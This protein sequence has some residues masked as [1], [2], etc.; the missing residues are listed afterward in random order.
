M[1]KIFEEE[2]A[3]DKKYCKV[4]DHFHCTGKSRGAAHTICNLR[5]SKPKNIPVISQN[6]SNYDYHFII[7][8]LAKE[9]GKINNLRKQE[10]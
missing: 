4:T 2:D 7:K 8:E 5:H 1:L 3:E 9:F 10:N 6:G